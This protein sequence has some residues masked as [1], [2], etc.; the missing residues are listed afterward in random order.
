M[1]DHQGLP[2]EHDRPSDEM[3]MQNMYEFPDA[4]CVAPRETDD[5]TLNDKVITYFL[6]E[7]IKPYEEFIAQLTNHELLDSVSN[8][9]YISQ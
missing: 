8:G 4:R 7:K 9:A 1:Q 2:P 3:V 6:D 5:A